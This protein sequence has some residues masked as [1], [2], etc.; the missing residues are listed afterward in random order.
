MKKQEPKIFGANKMLSGIQNVN[1][2]SN[3]GIVH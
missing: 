3:V 1:V 2:K